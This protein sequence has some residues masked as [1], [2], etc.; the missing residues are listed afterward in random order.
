MILLA[1]G[2]IVVLVL[3]VAVLCFARRNRNEFRKFISVGLVSHVAN[4]A[5]AIGVV[6][7]KVLVGVN[8]YFDSVSTGYVASYYVVMIIGILATLVDITN[9]L[10]YVWAAMISDDG[11]AFEDQ[12][13]WDSI[14]L[15]GDFTTSALSDLPSLV[16]S[17]A[18][19]VN[20]Q[21]GHLELIVALAVI[22]AFVCG[23]KICDVPQNFHLRHQ[24]G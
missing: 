17:C 14:I 15:F 11:I 8:L 24:Y 4:G 12:A 5:V 19:I 23:I 18:I 13:R 22:T 3:F 16:I 1:A 10:R 7:V 6:V 20:G 2:C 21:S 9:R